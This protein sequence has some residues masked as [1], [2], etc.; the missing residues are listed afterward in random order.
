M[1]ALLEKVLSKPIGL[2][3]ISARLPLSCNG[4]FFR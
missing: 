3:G 2:I 4:R 1:K